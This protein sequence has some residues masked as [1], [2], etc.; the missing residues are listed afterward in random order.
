MGPIKNWSEG[1]E[2]IG[3]WVKYIYSLATQSLPGYRIYLS[4]ASLFSLTIYFLLLFRSKTS[5]DI[6]PV[7][8]ETVDTVDTVDNVDNFDNVD[9]DFLG[10]LIQHKARYRAIAKFLLKN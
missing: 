1:S 9:A 4:F 6:T 5:Q 2:Q 3:L 10:N 7:L 8:V